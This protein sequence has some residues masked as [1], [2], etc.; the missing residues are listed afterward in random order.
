MPITTI[1]HPLTSRTST[2]TS[3]D[4]FR[5][6]IEQE[7]ITGSAIH[8]IL[9]QSA[10]EVV[11]DL[12]T[13][14]GGDVET[15][16]HDALNWR[17]T[18]FG[19]QVKEALFGAVFHNEDGTPWQVKL[20][21][22]LLD[23]DKPGKTRKY[24][25]PIGNGSRLF[26]P[27]IP[28]EIRRLIGARYGIQIPE[29]GSFWDWAEQHPEIPVF[30]TEGGKKA[31]AL[32]SLGYVAIALYGVNGGYRKL[33]GDTRS[34]IP[35]LQRFATP[36]RTF[37]LVFDQDE[38]P[39][40]RQRVAIALS[41]FGGLLVQAGSLVQVASWRA[42]QGKGVD[43]LIVGQGSAAFEKAYANALSFLDW[44]LW[45][46]L[47]HRLTH[48][49]LVRF[50][51]PDLSTLDIETIPLTGIIAIASAKGTG[52]TK[53]IRELV[54]T[55]QKAI[56][57]G[58]R[59]ALMQNLCTRL[60]LDYKGDLDK[61]RG[62][63]INGSAYTLR[64]GLCVD[65]FL[66]IDPNKFIG[67]DLILDEV[68]QVLRHLLTSSTCAKDGK[69]P[70]L[71]A[72]FREL[73]RVARRV[74]VADADLDNATL[75]YLKE[76]MGE[77]TPICL[78]RNDYQP[79]SYPVQF[80]DVPDRSV[81]LSRVI[82]AVQVLPK[83]KALFIATDSKGTS[84][85]IARLIQ[86]QYP[87]KRILLI[88]SETSGGDC[89][90]EFMQSPDSVLVR[91]E[92][93]III[94]SP[95]VATGVSIEMP[96]VIEAV[97]GVFTGVSSTDADMAQAL[98]RVR[99]PVQRVV[100]CAKVGS[101]F[102]NVSRSTNPLELKSHLQS[103]TTATVSLIR[104]SL[105]E[106]RL[107]DTEAAYNWQSDPHL[108]LYCR[109]A[110]SQNFSMLH[111]RDALRVRLQ[112]EGN[113]VQVE[114]VE[115]DPAMKLL[116]SAARQEI[117]EVEAEQLVGAA[118]L[119][120]SEV[121]QLEQ[122]EVVTP[123]QHQAIAK[124]YFKDFYCLEDLT[125]EDV[126]WDQEGRR[127]GELLNL[128]AQLYPHVALDRTARSLEKQLSWNQGLCPWDVSHTELRRQIRERIGLNKLLER[129][130][131][132][133]PWCKYDLAPYAAIARSMALQI[134]VALNFTIRPGMSDVQIIHQ[135]LSQMGIKMAKYRWSRSVMGYEGEK[136]KVYQLDAE[137]WEKVWDILEL[138]RIRRIQ[139]QQQSGSAPPSDQSLETGDPAAIAN[140][141]F[142][143]ES[144]K[145]VKN[146]WDK[147]EGDREVLEAIKG[148]VPPDV[149]DYLGLVA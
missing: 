52:K 91:D 67:C 113:Q 29:I 110:A 141:W 87:D 19:N 130:R 50:T 79:E 78:L 90:R 44:Q 3:L 71:L 119:T 139:I 27:V 133:W 62:E 65:S 137:H 122:Q 16:L 43:D 12:I 48:L 86:Q 131:Q 15:P 37:T 18:R 96:K 6:Q 112:F 32:L 21:A 102:S 9:F 76:L 121:L 135:L 108:N 7:F 85:A 83:G 36:G 126:L 123:E 134:K 47:E 35:D 13:Y 38:K 31:L 82:Q 128:E 147:A 115:S 30:L 75:D 118:D 145:E 142:A 111:L 148:I 94:C 146:L 66:S 149:L 55:V 117:R 105:R 33:P 5:Q 124:Y 59:I 4:Q 93:D 40:T 54:A 61:V 70:A 39:T 68:V 34:L 98:G 8:P 63:F 138:R 14:P 103:L 127:R 42:D 28:P 129:M 1:A 116:L 114:A 17:Y 2:S 25:T 95:S 10:I 140:P 136:L 24:E 20:S 46:R 92:Y 125:V 69:R 57:G 132:G 84:K 23:R 143:S 11:P 60:K 80:L 41:R 64:I 26:L 53:L 88:N 106:D 100:W 56:A 97:Y 104:S 120:Y 45:Q 51:T 144:L 58:H 49:P 22:P 101:N 109:L 72:R 73:L 74:I 99:E 89:E 77:E 107:P 81:I